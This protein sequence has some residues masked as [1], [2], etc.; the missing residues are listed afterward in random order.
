MCVHIHAHRASTVAI[1]TGECQEQFGAKACLYNNKTL[2]QLLKMN[3]HNKVFLYVETALH[4]QDRILV[5]V[6]SHRIAN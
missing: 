5:Q 6:S 4:K 1:H 3:L 2:H